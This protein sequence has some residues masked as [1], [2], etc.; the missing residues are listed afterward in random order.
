MLLKVRYLNKMVLYICT[1]YAMLLIRLNGAVTDLL[2]WLQTGDSLKEAQE[3][4][5]CRSE[6]WIKK[7]KTQTTSQQCQQGYLSHLG[8]GDDKRLTKGVSNKLEIW[9]FKSGCVLGTGGSN[10]CNWDVESHYGNC[11]IN[12]FGAW[13]FQIKIRIYWHLL[14]W[15][16][17]SI[18]HACECG[19]ILVT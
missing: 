14:H 15:L 13:M 2:D 19:Y 8:L 3:Q 17:K 10:K 1:I 5:D 12:I 11:R 6:V 16:M 7:K 4:L 18:I 9:A